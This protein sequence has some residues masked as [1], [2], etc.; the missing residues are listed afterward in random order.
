MPATVTIATC[1]AMFA[2][3]YPLLAP[4]AR[5]SVSD[6]V[7][8]TVRIRKKTHVTST[9][10][11]NAS[12]RITANDWLIEATPGQVGDRGLPVERLDAVDLRR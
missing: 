1:S 8:C 6:C 12:S 9:T 4:T 11:T 2:S 7:F 3:R 10:T 5:S